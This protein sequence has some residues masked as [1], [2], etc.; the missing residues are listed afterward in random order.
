MLTEKND[1]TLNDIKNNLELLEFIDNVK[2]IDHTHSTKKAMIDITMYGKEIR[3]FYHNKKLK[4]KNLELKLSDEWS[5]LIP[6]YS[7]EKTDSLEKILEI[8]TKP[9]WKDYLDSLH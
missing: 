3:L 4:K 5:I 8:I 6:E 7:L 2:L 9:A 1:I